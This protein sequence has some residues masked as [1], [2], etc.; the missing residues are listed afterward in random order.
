MGA[1]GITRDPHAGQPN[2]DGVRWWQLQPTRQFGTDPRGALVH[3][4][5]CPDLRGLPLLT[6]AEAVAALQVAADGVR[7]AQACPRCRPDIG[8]DLA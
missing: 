3:R 7:A 6:R 8:L 5:D 2:R 4:G 1:A